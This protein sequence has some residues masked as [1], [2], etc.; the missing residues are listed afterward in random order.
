MI[1]HGRAVLAVM[2]L[3]AGA[4]VALAHAHLERADPRVGSS[5]AASPAQV[6]LWFSER[7]EPA[8][9]SVQVL[10]ESGRRVDAGD[11][12]VAP[13]DRKLLLVS[14]PPLP[15]GTYRVR[16]RVVSVDTHVQ[17]GDFTFRVAP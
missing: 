10:D 13:S 15:A 7:I 8:F 12:Q 2:L 1:S 16:W 17:E 14:V 6:R 3:L 4:S 9:S 5:V 11:A